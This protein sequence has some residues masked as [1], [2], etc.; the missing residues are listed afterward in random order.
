MK[1]KHLFFVT[2][3]KRHLKKRT[4]KLYLSYLDNI[5]KFKMALTLGSM[6]TCLAKIKKVAALSEKRGLRD[7]IN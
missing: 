2:T 6:R 4:L 5:I 1:G 7:R 3:E